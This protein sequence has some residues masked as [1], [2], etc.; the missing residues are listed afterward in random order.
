MMHKIK[1]EIRSHT[2]SSIKTPDSALYRDYVSKI[3]NLSTTL[4]AYCTAIGESEV[5]WH[6]LRATQRRFAEQFVNKYPDEDIVR[7][8]ARISAAQSQQL[9]DD[10]MKNTDGSCTPQQDELS[11]LIRG[12]LTEIAAIEQQYKM[13]TNLTTDLKMYTKKV[14]DL[15]RGKKPVDEKLSRNMEK[16]ENARAKYEAKVEQVV[17]QMRRV[18]E[19]R[20]VVLRAAY[21]AFWGLQ[22]QSVDSMSEAVGAT[23]S[24]VFSSARMMR[25]VDFANMTDAFA[26]QFN[27]SCDTSPEPFASQGSRVV[28]SDAPFLPPNG[29]PMQQTSMPLSQVQAGNNN[30]DIQNTYTP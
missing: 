25:G 23:R 19:R 13:V 2:S 24:F 18:Y 15:S 12:Y 22:I 30:M 3:A 10:C 7:G 20:G 29:V 17:E 9:A 26:A 21:V 6:S 4:K 5:T 8:N 14:E 28:G 1:Q 11:M 16:R 27:S